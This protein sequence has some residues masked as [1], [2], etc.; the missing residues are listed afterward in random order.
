MHSRPLVMHNA[1]DFDNLPLVIVLGYE[2]SLR[3]GLFLLVLAQLFASLALAVRIM[4]AAN[5]TK[6]AMAAPAN[7]LRTAPLIPRPGPE[8]A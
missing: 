5:T 7:A 1:R 6:Q 3:S 8:S 2:A 4:L